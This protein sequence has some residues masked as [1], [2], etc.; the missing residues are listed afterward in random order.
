MLKYVW[1]TYV[2][3]YERLEQTLNDLPE[4]EE[5]FSINT[6]GTQAVVITRSFDITTLNIEKKKKRLFED[7]CSTQ[8]IKEDEAN[9]VIYN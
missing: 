9:Y 7:N 6:V 5:V 2:T 3:S 4:G 1:H 8:K